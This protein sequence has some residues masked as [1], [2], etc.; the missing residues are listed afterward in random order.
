MHNINETASFHVGYRELEEELA[1]GTTQPVTPKTLPL[2]ELHEKPSVF[3]PRVVGDEYA[4]K[5]HIK[6]LMNATMS[7]PK[8]VLNPIIVWWSG[9]RWLVLDGHHR[10]MAYKRLNEQGKGA[11][12]VP[13]KV[14]SGTLHKAHLESMKLNMKDKLNVDKDDKVTK[15][16]HLLTLNNGMTYR[17]ISGITGTSMGTLSRMNE[18]RKELIYKYKDEWLDEIEGLTWKEVQ[19]LDKDT[20]FDEEAQ[21][22]LTQEWSKRLRRAFGK[23]PSKQPEIF[24]NA[25]LEWSEKASREV[26][27][28]LSEH[29]KYDIDDPYFDN[30]DF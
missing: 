22:R 13:V 14:Y 20:T 3:Q 18:R 8:N 19:R 10:L 16:W 26:Y 2:E 12:R 23:Q 9:A 11:K 21:D 29:F 6:T 28:F 25:M 5:N 4:T 7:E 15:A 27:N 17:H 24:T 30:C 1:N